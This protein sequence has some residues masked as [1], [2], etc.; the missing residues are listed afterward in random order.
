MAEP[1]LRERAA[2]ALKDA[3][4]PRACLDLQGYRRGGLN[5]APAPEMNGQPDDAR[6]RAAERHVRRLGIAA[7][8]EGA[9]PERDI[10]LL[11]ADG[12]AAHACLAGAREAIVANCQALGFRYAALALY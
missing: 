11:V 12:D 10:A 1:A 9:G 7:R 5:E 8:V 4:F 3:G 6:T 2:A